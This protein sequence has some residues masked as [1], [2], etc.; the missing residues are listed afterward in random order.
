M[1]T[2]D[3][4]RYLN[5]FSNLKKEFDRRCGVSGW[6]LHDLR[7]TPRTP[8]VAGRSRGPPRTPDVA[9]RS[10]GPPRTP[11]VAGRS[12]GG[13]HLAPLW[14]LC[15]ARLTSTCPWPFRARE[16][17][18]SCH[19]RFLDSLTL[20]ARWPQPATTPASENP[21]NYF[22]TWYCDSGSALHLPID[23]VKQSLD[24]GLPIKR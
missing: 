2:N 22:P 7:R 3:G 6:T 4:W 11:D 9:G 5:G 17:G 21:A 16:T 8:D 13:D 12:R 19:G 14:S 20:A 24:S 15:L 23:T 10:R 18:S 1:V